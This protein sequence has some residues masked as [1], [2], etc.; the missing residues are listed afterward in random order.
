M[1]IFELLFLEFT[2]L[3]RLSAALSR[4]QNGGKGETERAWEQVAESRIDYAPLVKFRCI[5]RVTTGIRM[6]STAISRKC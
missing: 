4:I 1:P 6:R 2:F 3:V 5:Q